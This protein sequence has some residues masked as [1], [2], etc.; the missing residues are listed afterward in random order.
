MNETIAKFDRIARGY[1]ERDY[2]DPERYAERRAAV[3][4]SLGPPLA[5]GDSVLDLACGDGIMARPL[6]ARGLRYRGVDA[7]AAMVDAARARAPEATFAVG[8]FEEFEPADPVDV[9]IF[10]RTIYLVEDRVAFFRR[11]AGYTRKKLVVDL[12]PRADAPGPILAD[13]RAA[14]FSRLE[15]RPFFLP[16]RRRL[17]AAALPAVDALERSGPLAALLVRGYGRLF[18]AAS[19]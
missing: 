7:S 5:P 2:A 6:L 18:C 8:R 3:I 17:P 19:S 12:R 4:A 10:L 13:L 1:S 11:V 14:G 9:T 16:Q 15:L